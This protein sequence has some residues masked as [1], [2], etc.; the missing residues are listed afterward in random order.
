MRYLLPHECHLLTPHTV[1]GPMALHLSLT[2]LDWGGYITCR[3]ANSSNCEVKSIY[4]ELVFGAG[5]WSGTQWSCLR[6]SWKTGEIPTKCF[7]FSVLQLGSGWGA[8]LDT[9]FPM[10][11]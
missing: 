6:N 3:F 10:L 2:V 9:K 8:L 4:F 5:G 7:L 11:L 1:E